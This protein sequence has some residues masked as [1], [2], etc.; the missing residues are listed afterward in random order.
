MTKPPMMPIN[1]PTNSLPRIINGLAK[2]VRPDGLITTSRATTAIIAPIASSNM[3][4]ASNRLAT[5]DCSL[6]RRRRGE[7]TVGPVTMTSKPNKIEVFQ[8]HPKNNLAEKVPPIAVTIAPIEIKLRIV[9]PIFFNRLKR[10]FIPPSNRMTATANPTMIGSASPKV[11][12]RIILRA[13][14]PVRI[15]PA[16]N[17]TIPGIRIWRAAD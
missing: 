15:P 10:R 4:S 17:N 9:R 13:S 11:S 7:I 2:K 8:F 16:N 6:I 1:P 12:G 3:P 14:G 5:E